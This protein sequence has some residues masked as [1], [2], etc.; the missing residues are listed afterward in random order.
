MESFSANWFATVALLAWPVVALWLYATR[1]VNQATL[2]TI[3]GA[4][5]LLPVGASIKLAEGIPQLDK[6]SIPTLA[7]LAGCILVAKR[8]LRLWNG[9]GLAEIL[10]LALLIGPFVTSELNGD[11]VL[12]GSVTLPAVGAYD[13]LSAVV[14][15]LIFVLPFILGRQV[16]GRLAD[17]Q[18]IFETLVI[19]ALLYSLPM[20]FE[21]RMSPQLHRWIYG[22]SPFGFAT[23]ARYGGFRPAVLMENG[24]VVAFFMMTAIAAAATLS[25]LRIRPSTLPTGG[26]LAYLSAVLV[27]CKS[28]GALLYGI[29]LVPLVYFVKP[30]TQVRIAVI[31]AAIAL[32]YPL[33]RAEGLVPVRSMTDLA[34]SFD[35]ERAQSLEFRFDNEQR[36]LERARE[37]PM[38]GWGRFARNRIFDEYGKDVSVTDG[39]WIITL[40]QFGLFGF[41]A[42]FGLLALP[43]IRAARVLRFAQSERD[44]VL[45][46]A[47][48]LIIGINMIDLLPN[49][50][51]SP[52]TWLLA[53]ALLGRAES[54]RM[55]APIPRRRERWVTTTPGA[56]A[57]RLGGGAGA[58]YS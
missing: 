29:A 45:M 6:V 16:L 5:L 20:L 1:P 51:L 14:A 35:A 55:A 27:L 32:T 3:L 2:W 50:S 33:L 10:L 34:A 41:V 9:L 40:G 25:R 57:A 18:K 42:E 15:Q 58:P 23:E 31:L 39:R 44:S 54:V 43:I 7:T 22:Y 30:R 12:N 24:L 52:W 53:G 48:A 26:I 21:I 17:N 56:E 47:L 11:A 46:T 37:R 38:F 28:L 13:G 49:A 8:P 4:Q 36:L 19:A